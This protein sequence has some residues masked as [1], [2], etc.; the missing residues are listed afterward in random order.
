MKQ[1]LGKGSNFKKIT[2]K[3][4]TTK[5]KKEYNSLSSLQC[6]VSHQTT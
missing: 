1:I 3:V 6:L 5:H 2:A 4:P